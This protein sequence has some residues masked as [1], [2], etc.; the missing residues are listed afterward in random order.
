MLTVLLVLY[1][2]GMADSESL[3]ADNSIFGSLTN[4]FGVDVLLLPHY[5]TVWL[6][7]TRCRWKKINSVL[8]VTI[9]TYSKMISHHIAKVL[10]FSSYS[11]YKCK[12]ARYTLN[13]ETSR[14]QHR[15]ASYLK[16][17]KEKGMVQLY[18]P[19]QPCVGTQPRAC[20]RYEEEKGPKSYI[21]RPHF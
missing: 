20:I 18:P 4:N 14:G 15:L 9:G 17:Y 12:L 11:G 8:R 6:R 13:Y 2:K 5:K 19:L 21:V 7:T 3:D 10:H 16:P 1:L